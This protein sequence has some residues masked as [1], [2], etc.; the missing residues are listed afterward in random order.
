MVPVIQS[1]LLAGLK[2]VR[3]AFFTR[4][5]GVSSGLY[6]SLNVGIGSSDAP[7][8]VTENRK[9]IGDW[10]GVT[11]DALN[12]CYQIHSA[13]AHVVEA[14]WGAYRPQGDALATD[15]PSI[16]LGVLTADCAPVLLADAQGH[17]VASAHAGWQGALTGIVEAAVAAME[18][19]GAQ[20]ERI[21][22][23]IGPCIGPKSYE[24][25]LEFFERFE[26]ERP[27]SARF[28]SP[29]AV[30]DKR[31]F[32]LPGFVLERLAEA[33]VRQAEWTGHDTCADEA[34]FFSNRRAFRAGEPDFGRMMSG[35]MLG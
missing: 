22:A 21:V 17:V 31:M 10:F 29:G 30:A 20:R 34:L 14:P 12:T 5:G 8:D 23:A 1:P 4:Q 33:G 19:I 11:P 32:D 25:G 13:K 28:F 2:G 26:A 16:A 27:G 35:I 7:A 15:Q 18:R 9:R 24:V 6:D 3:H